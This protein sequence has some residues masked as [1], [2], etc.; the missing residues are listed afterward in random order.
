MDIA[1]DLHSHS[2]FAGGSGGLSTSKESLAENM[3]KAHKRFLQADANSLLK[4]IQVLGSGDIQFGPWLDFFKQDF[5]E[6]NGL[7]VLKDGGTGELRYLLQTEVIITAELSKKKRKSV[8]TVILFPH[9]EAIQEFK[10]LLTKFEV[11]QEKLA[12]PFVVLQDNQNVSDF[13][14][15]V[16]EIDNMI[17]I[18]PAHVMTP[19]G[20]YGGNNGVNTLDSFFGEFGNE[21]TTFETGLS[22]DPVILSLI[23][24]LDN[25]TLL[26]NSD[27]HSAQLHRIGR[28]FTVLD[29]NQLSYNSIVDSLRNQ[30]IAYSLEFPVTEGRFF[31]TGHRA[32]R[33]K[34]GAHN[35][36]Q[37]CYFSP[38]HVPKDNICP[39]CNKKLTKGVLQRAFEISKSQGEE[40]TLDQSEITQKF[41][42]GV[43][44]TE[45]IAGALQIKSSDSK[46]VLKHYKDVIAVFGNEVNLWRAEYDKVE[47]VIP[48]KLPASIRDAI[49]M[50]KQEKFG[51]S[52]PGFDGTYGSLVFGEKQDFFGHNVIQN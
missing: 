37:Y 44:L 25:K 19:E 33:K 42:H 24:E 14:Y 11:K 45:V 6:E 28:E 7:F 17:E 49:L 41:L 29:M 47:P 10:Q 15:K 20:V 3:K 22:A 8:H 5:E 35:T 21:L 9:Y 12:R 32:G 34:P 43:P 50:I 4:G 23:P 46:T 52:P 18:I 36:D 39:I 31:L 13:L 30:K 27:A 1:V 16:T 26:S 51:F 48:K 40:R 2:M 38:E